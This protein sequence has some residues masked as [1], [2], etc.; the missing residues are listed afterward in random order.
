MISIFFLVVAQHLHLHPES[1]PNN[2]G[3]KITDIIDIRVNHKI[4]AGF[5]DEISSKVLNLRRRLLILKSSKSNNNNNN[6]SNL[7]Y[8]MDDDEE[9]EDPNDAD[10]EFYPVV[11]IVRLILRIFSQKKSGNHDLRHFDSDQSA[12]D[13]QKCVESLERVFSIKNKFMTALSDEQDKLYKADSG[14]KSS[15]RSTFLMNKRPLAGVFNMPDDLEA[16]FKKDEIQTLTM[17]FIIVSKALNKKLGL[18]KDDKYI[19]CRWFQL[20]RMLTVR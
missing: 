4:G 10:T 16:P 15:G 3:L 7:G 8:D 6:N 18:P 19:G 17:F 14:R 2:R 1:H 9:D 13:L 20:K 11:F 12:S 5:E